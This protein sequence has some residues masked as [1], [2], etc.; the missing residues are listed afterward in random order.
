MALT[1]G[2][3]ATVLAVLVATV[4]LGLAGCQNPGGSGGAGPSASTSPGAGLKIPDNARK[5]AESHNGQRIIHRLLREGTV[6]VQ[7]A[8][9]G[10]VA[11]SG[12]VRASSNVTVDPKANAIAVNDVQVRGDPKLDVAKGYR[13]YFVGK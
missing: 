3:W 4:A 12:R 5:V 7:E 1:N 9:S 6:Y 8:E 10:R 13:L 2:R 11:Y